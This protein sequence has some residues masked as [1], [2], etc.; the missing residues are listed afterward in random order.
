MVEDQEVPGAMGNHLRTMCAD[1]DTISNQFSVLF[2]ALFGTSRAEAIEVKNEICH[3][4]R[5]ESRP[6]RP[7][8]RFSKSG[9]S[10][11]IFTLALVNA[12]MAVFVMF[13]T[14]E[15]VEDNFNF[16]LTDHEKRT[17]WWS[18]FFAFMFSFLGLTAIGSVAMTIF[19]CAIDRPNQFPGLVMGAEG[20]LFTFLHSP[21]ES[22]WA[23]FWG[24]P[25]DEGPPG[26][27]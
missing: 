26:E 2:M 19:S 21:D 12:G 14:W 9:F 23:I 27:V 11:F 8:Q 3:V 10:A 7:F 13:C 1:P 5:G 16:A 18:L 22:D 15:F 17:L 25:Y 4:P 20:S 24:R 6:D